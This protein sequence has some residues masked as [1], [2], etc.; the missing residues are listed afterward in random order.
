MSLEPEKIN[1][2]EHYNAGR[3]EVIEFIYDQQLNFSLGCA[4][5]YITRAGRKG[6][7]DKA[8]EDLKKAAR[9]IEFEIKQRTTGN[10][11]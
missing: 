6:G 9:Y 1:H 8:V 7:D 4:V 3:I 10:P 11:N 2:P 5:K